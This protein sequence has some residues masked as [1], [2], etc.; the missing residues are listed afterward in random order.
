MNSY[1]Q[2]YADSERKRKFSVAVKELSSMVPQPAVPVPRL[3]T[4]P[5]PRTRGSLRIR[6]RSAATIAAAR[7]VRQQREDRSAAQ[8]YLDQLARSPSGTA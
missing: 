2:N 6:K 5:A 4:S 3:Q 1:L 7:L 8:A